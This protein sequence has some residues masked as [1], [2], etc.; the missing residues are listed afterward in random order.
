MFK[1]A[2]WPVCFI[3]DTY[4][5]FP[6]LFIDFRAVKGV[7][8]TAYISLFHE[9]ELMK[10]QIYLHDCRTVTCDLLTL[11]YGSASQNG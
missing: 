8:S 9:I 11:V 3:F 10:P 4:E 6:Y 5:Y 1:I 7:A 2:L